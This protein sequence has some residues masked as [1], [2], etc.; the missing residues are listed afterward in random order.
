MP[1]VSSFLLPVLLN[2]SICQYLTVYKDILLSMLVDHSKIPEHTV[3]LFS[4]VY[5]ACLI[6]YMF[7]QIT[8]FSPAVVRR[9]L[10]TVRTN[11]VRDAF[12]HMGDHFKVLQSPLQP[13]E[14]AMHTQALYIVAAAGALSLFGLCVEVNIAAARQ[15]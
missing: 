14:E 4:F 5:Y 6:Y 2:I 12:F 13:S 7:E 3:S 15:G 10:T 1:Q 9:L 11:R 8:Q